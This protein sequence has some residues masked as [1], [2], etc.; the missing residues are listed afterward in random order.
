MLNL[1]AH[2]ISRVLISLS[3]LLCPSSLLAGGSLADLLEQEKDVSTFADSLKKVG[4][5]DMLN[6]ELPITI[7]APSNAALERD[8]ST[9]LL[10]HVMPTRGNAERFRD[11]MLLHIAFDRFDD[12][13][14]DYDYSKIETLAGTCFEVVKIGDRVR[15]GPS[16]VM[17]LVST[18]TGN[19]YIIDRLLWRPWKGEKVGCDSAAVRIRE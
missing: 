19:L 11:L 18:G 5:W 12:P 10:T 4:L 2:A 9:F 16:F 14:A 13:M 3:L 7:L 15:V 17:K 1:S 6:N 8:G